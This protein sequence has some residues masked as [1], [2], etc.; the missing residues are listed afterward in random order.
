MQPLPQGGFALIAA[1]GMMS[2]LLILA[3]SLTLQIQVELRNFDSSKARLLA[4]ENARLGLM[5]ALGKLQRHAG[6]DQRVTASAEILGDEAITNGSRFWTG[7][8]NTTEVSAEPAWL[9]SSPDNR[10]P[11]PSISG[12][13][14]IFSPQASSNHS[15]TGLQSLSVRVPVAP[16]GSAGDRYAYWIA[17]EGVKAS[18]APL[19]DRDK[20]LN[21]GEQKPHEIERQMRQRS[22][23]SPGRPE[24]VSKEAY[25]AANERGYSL[26]WASELPLAWSSDPEEQLSLSK[27]MEEFHHDFTAR[28]YGL[29]TNTMEGGFRYDLSSLDRLSPDLEA[30]MHTWINDA[31]REALN[32]WS[33]TAAGPLEPRVIAG[34]NNQAD[35]PTLKLTPIITELFLGAALSGNASS[36]SNEEV[37]IYYLIFAELWN[38]FTTSL[39][40]SE[41]DSY[42]DII[43]RVTGLPQVKLR[44]ETRGITRQIEIPA[45]IMDLDFYDIIDG[46]E[47]DHFEPGRITWA[48]NP[49]S[50]GGGSV[51]V[52]DQEHLRRNGVYIVSEPVGFIPGT[53]VEDFVGEF[54]ATDLRIEFFLKRTAFDDPVDPHVHFW[55]MELNGFEEFLIGYEGGHRK[56]TGYTGSPTQFFRPRNTQAHGVNRASIN[57]ARNSFNYWFRLDEE[58]FTPGNDDFKQIIETNALERNQT[59]ID[60]QDTAWH[61]LNRI[62]Q[63]GDFPEQTQRDVTFSD[64]DFFSGKDSPFDSNPDRWAYFKDLPTRPPVEL[65]QLNFL[66]FVEDHYEKLGHPNQSE[67]NAVYDR[68]FMSGLTS[69]TSIA[70]PIRSLSANPRYQIVDRQG[71]DNFEAWAGDLLVVGAFNINSTSAAAWAEVLAG[72]KLEAWP[73]GTDEDKTPVNLEAAW[74]NMP[75]IGSGMFDKVFSGHDDYRLPLHKDGQGF[76][77]FEN[78]VLSNLPR[79]TPLPPA[80]R[81]GFRELDDAERRRL[82]E[83]ISTRIRARNRPFFSI[84]EFF[85][86]GILQAAI[87]ATPELNS[88]ERGNPIPAYSPAYF[89]QVSMAK[90]AGS[91]LSARSDTFRIIVAGEHLDRASGNRVEARCEAVVQ[92]LPR[93]E[94]LGAPASRTERQFNIVDFQ[95]L[96]EL[97]N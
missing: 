94:S 29:L 23:L 56:A 11:D 31:V 63:V 93:R 20:L 49:R 27:K 39:N 26:I 46:E 1:L 32:L 37:F 83:K 68:Y 89:S 6:P 10:S 5:V 87:E 97:Q 84:R 92:R 47:T 38:P 12:D 91:R 16:I 34:D 96:N 36:P 4:R 7:V 14:I 13:F 82:G 78:F 66:T 21:Q 90:N 73:A 2:V 50:S 67:L 57:Q 33:E 76:R 17:D 3:L 15:N 45:L 9:V 70:P 53:T 71:F 28:S 64:L 42:D 41:R 19:F 43:V 30:P 86:S 62:Y 44:N 61:G 54:S 25:Q 58:L 60:L 81:Q 24:F 95:W 48:G 51:T 80:F 55:T 22:S 35:N 69:E 52:D 65:A 8:W 59:S 88:D 79:E 75:D 74:F 72:S 18:L 77:A 85:D 40:F